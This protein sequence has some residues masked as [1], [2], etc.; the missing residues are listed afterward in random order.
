VSAR[1]LLLCLAASCSA[2]RT[3][4]VPELRATE[5]L[6]PAHQEVL[7]AWR[8]RG[9]DWPL[10]RERALEDPALRMFLV[11]NALV[12]LI[13]AWQRGDFTFADPG[14]Y[15]EVRAEVVALGSA[16]APSLA[17]LLGVGNGYGPA[18]ASDVLLR[19]GPAGVEA[20]LSE[21]S[22]ADAELVRG[23]ALDLLGG[24]GELSPALEERV[25]QA[26]VDA[27]AMDPAWIVRERAARTLARRARV[28]SAGATGEA[29]ARLREVVAA[30]SRA[31]A[32]ED[33]A[34]AR[35]AAVGLGLVGDRRAVPALVNH[36]ERVLRGDDLAA[37]RAV[38]RGLET[39]TGVQGLRTPAQWRD[40]L[41]SSRR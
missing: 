36:L 37:A 12:D 34:V 35:A 39:L 32:D 2:P 23:Q 26:A 24:F 14:G 21:A 38:Q 29:D 25:R 18:I 5:E 27:L 31:L 40:W 4:G 13:R 41:R 22:G 20:L 9:A 7:A 11:D 17:A 10:V 1:W 28:G 19:M 30:L 33:P 15:E 8:A 6:P 16:A 3:E